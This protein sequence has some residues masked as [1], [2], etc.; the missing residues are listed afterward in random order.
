M[1]FLSAS[2]SRIGTCGGN[3]SHTPSKVASCDDLTTMGIRVTHS[4]RRTSYGNVA[5]QGWTFYKYD[6]I[7]MKIRMVETRDT[8]G[9]FLVKR[10]NDDLAKKKLRLKHNTFTLLN[11]GNV[12]FW[13][14]S[15]STTF[16]NYQKSL[17]SAVLKYEFDSVRFFALDSINQ[18]SPM[19]VMLFHLSDYVLTNN[20]LAAS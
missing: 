20:L 13:S 1:H 6:R 12:K 16:E 11:Q 18:N 14:F 10:S 9:L 5:V 7:A 3:S 4:V 2:M 17:I 15:G 19:W 8:Q